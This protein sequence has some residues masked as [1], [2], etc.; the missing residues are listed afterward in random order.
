MAVSVIEWLAAI[1]AVMNVFIYG[2]FLGAER[3]A[4]FWRSR[5][6]EGHRHPAA[7]SKEE[8]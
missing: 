6:L 1:L 5:Y 4:R 8:R 3:S 7:P 2:L